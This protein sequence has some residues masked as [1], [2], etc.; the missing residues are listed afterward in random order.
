M[1]TAEILRQ[2]LLY[3]PETGIFTWRI[4]KQKVRPGLVAGKTKPNG[5]IEI[6]VNRISYQAHRLAW[7]YMSGSWPDGDIDHINRKPSDNRFCNL[8]QATRAQNLCNVGALSTS[9]TGVRG[10]D[11]HKASGKFRARIRFDGRRVELG[12]F[13]SV[14]EARAAYA[15]ARERH[16]GAFG[17]VDG[18]N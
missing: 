7:L 11:F 2:Q 15:R 17:L 6:R 14:E 1:L 4:R 13:E 10:V 12:L 18:G 5:Y 9:S 3:D 8:R 16:H